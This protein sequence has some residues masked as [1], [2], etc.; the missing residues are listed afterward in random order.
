MAGSMKVM[1]KGPVV[2]MGHGTWEERGSVLGEG[3][4]WA[5]GVVDTR[6]CRALWSVLQILLFLLRGEEYC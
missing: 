3:I 1:C 2:G 5:G 4:R 6:P